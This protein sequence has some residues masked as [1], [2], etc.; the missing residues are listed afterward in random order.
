[1][2]FVEVEKEQVVGHKPPRN[3]FFFVV[4]FIFLAADWSWLILRRPQRACGAL[5][6]HQQVWPAWQSLGN[7]HCG[8]DKQMRRLGLFVI[9]SS[10]KACQSLR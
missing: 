10:L 9:C 5:A 7:I 2:L 1:V 6:M 3:E 8:S 4:F